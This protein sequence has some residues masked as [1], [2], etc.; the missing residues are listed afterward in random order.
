MS[1]LLFAAIAM[2]VTF[3]LMI[4]RLDLRKFLGYAG[5][6]DLVF[7]FLMLALFANTFSGVVAASLA[8]VVMT[9]TLEVLKRLIGYK[10][11]V[12]RGFKLRWEYTPGAWNV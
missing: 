12:R 1:V 2:V 4:N 6:V 5:W 9:I 10:R 7:S 3:L 11:L 8:G